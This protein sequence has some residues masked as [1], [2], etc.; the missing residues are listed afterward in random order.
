MRYR[1]ELQTGG[2]VRRRFHV[3]AVRAF[4]VGDYRDGL[5][6]Q[7][8]GAAISAGLPFRYRA[9]F[10]RSSLWY[11][12]SLFRADL[13]RKRDSAPMGTVFATLEKESN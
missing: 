11:G 5:P 13:N 2:V 8:D 4:L 9:A 10:G 6:Y 7:P 12:E 3:P 1:V